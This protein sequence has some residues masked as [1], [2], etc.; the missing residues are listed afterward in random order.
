L[1]DVSKTKQQ[2]STNRNKVNGTFEEV[3]MTFWRKKFHARVKVGK[4]PEDKK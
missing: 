2:L 4:K 1:F 3:L